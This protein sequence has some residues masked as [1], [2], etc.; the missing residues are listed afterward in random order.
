M[1]EFPSIKFIVFSPQGDKIIEFVEKYSH[2]FEEVTILDKKSEHIL[3]HSILYKDELERLIK[4]NVDKSVIFEL[5][6]PNLDEIL[7]KFLNKEEI[8]ISDRKQL[9]ELSKAI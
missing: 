6:K 5:E 2:F 3:V 8:T 9:F 7:D 1:Y 4:K